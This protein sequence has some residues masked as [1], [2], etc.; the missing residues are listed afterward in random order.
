MDVLAE[1]WSSGAVRT[2]GSTKLRDA[3]RNRVRDQIDTFINAY[4]SVNP[5][6][7]RKPPGRIQAATRQKRNPSG[8]LA[9][10]ASLNF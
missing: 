7:L 4:L 10:V 8:G 9:K 5:K 6:T 2:S 3:V 1:V